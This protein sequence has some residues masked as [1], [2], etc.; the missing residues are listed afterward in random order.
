M[1]PPFEVT[2]SKP[3]PVWFGSVKI[4]SSETPELN[5]GDTATATEAAPVKKPKDPGRKP[6]QLPPYKVLL[7]N[8]EVNSVEHVIRSILQ[9]TTLTPEEAINRTLEAHETG[10]ALLLVTHRER[11][12]LYQ[13]QFTSNGITVTIE[14]TEN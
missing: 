4:K 10:L 13:E 14:P 9:I 12:E 8:D 5:G 6:R 7:H 1:Y 3:T 11:A 2:T